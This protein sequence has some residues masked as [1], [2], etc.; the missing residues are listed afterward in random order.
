MCLSL[1]VCE[2][3]HDIVMHTTGLRFSETV[4]I[5]YYKSL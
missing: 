3:I 4:P 5:H 1:Y 2:Y